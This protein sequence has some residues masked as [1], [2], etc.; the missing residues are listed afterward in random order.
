MKL[1]SRFVGGADTLRHRVDGANSLRVFLRRLGVAFV[2]VVVLTGGG[3]RR[4]ERGR[5]PEA[6]EHSPDQSAQQHAD[7]RA[8]PALPRTTSSS[9]PTRA[10]SRTR[11]PRRRRSAAPRTSATRRSDVMMVVHVVPALDTAFVVSFPR[12]TEVDIPGHGH[13]LLNAA[14]AFGGPALTIKTFEQD[15]GIP[16]QHYLAV[17]FLGFE[18]IVD[19]IGHVKIYFP[20][21]ARDF[22][23]GL[24]QPVAGCMSLNG[25]EALEYARSRHYAIPRERCRPIPI[26][27]RPERLERGSPRRPRSHQAPA[28]LPAD[29]R[30]DR[31]RPRRVESDDRVPP[32]RRRRVEPHR[33][34]D[35][36]EQRPEVARAHVSRARSRR[37]SR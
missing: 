8:S 15:F 36:L 25:V 4:G 1:Q 13:N 10:S 12:D 18:K 22:Y 28:V 23:T 32:D 11:R 35:A 24:N 3:R 30:P 9:D 19:A 34:R 21:P 7:A 31:A 6:L 26:P 37:R 14:F 33:R 5:E 16:I 27:T 20:T 2:V 29:A 17:D